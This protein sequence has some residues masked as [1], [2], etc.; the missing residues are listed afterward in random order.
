MAGQKK[1]KREAQYTRMTTQRNGPGESLKI[2]EIPG[3]F[4]EGLKGAPPTVTVSLDNVALP[5][6]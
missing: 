4:L 2:M 6:I 5:A 3:H 1:R